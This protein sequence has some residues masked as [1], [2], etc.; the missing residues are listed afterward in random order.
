MPF[1]KIDNAVLGEALKRI[2]RGEKD[3]LEII[4][5]Y[6][7]DPIYALA[8]S[9]IRDARLAEDIAQE[10]LLRVLDKA[11]TYHERGTAKAWILSITRNLALDAVRQNK[12]ISLTDAWQ[13][14]PCTDPAFSDVTMSEALD[15]LEKLDRQIIIF[16]IVARLSYREIAS[17]LDISPGNI[18]VRHSRALKKLKTYYEK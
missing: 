8:V 4:Y 7:K 18:R 6:M 9:I 17:I 1:G 16:R 12:S 11:D 13:E 5:Q 15:G 10:T 14:E 3:A 2:K